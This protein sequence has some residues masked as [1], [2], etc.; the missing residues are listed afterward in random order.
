MFGQEIIHKT[1]NFV[2]ETLK[3]A[4]SGHDWYHIERVWKIAKNICL[5]EQG[6]NL[7]VVELSAL[8]HDIADHKFH[9]GDHE[10]GSKVSEDFLKS[11][12]L[13][14]D[15]IEQVC[16]I[17]KNISFKGSNE[18]NVMNSLEGKIVQ[19]ADRLD[20]LGAIGVARSFSY[21]GFRN[22]EMYNPYIPPKLGMTWEEYKKHEGTT[23]N[24][25]YEKLFLLKDMMNTKRGKELA[26]ERHKKMEEFIKEFLKEWNGEDLI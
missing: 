5:S 7:Q 18:I 13:D 20:A 12:G 21:G 16:N 14:S 9:N 11:I 19:D 17:V 3:G 2:K 4:E 6:V 10:K 1:I 26:E 22:R 15:T 23:V 25:F 24:H 8:L